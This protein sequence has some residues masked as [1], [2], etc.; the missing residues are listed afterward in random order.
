MG[1]ASSGFFLVSGSI[2]TLIMEGRSF[3]YRIVSDTSFSGSGETWV[4]TGD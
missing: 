3:T 4:R 1:K 2:L